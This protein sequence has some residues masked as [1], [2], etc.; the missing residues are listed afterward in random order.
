[1]VF[2]TV[3]RNRRRPQLLRRPDRRA[4]GDPITGTS[5]GQPGLR[6]LRIRS[7]A[8]GPPPRR[9]RQLRCAP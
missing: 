5:R 6:P 2:A 3:A 7:A 4:A 9:G 8:A 1:V